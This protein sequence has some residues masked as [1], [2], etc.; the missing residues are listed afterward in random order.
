MFSVAFSWTESKISANLSYV[1]VRGEEIW[2]FRR[3]AR[4]IV[5]NLIR[6]SRLH[7]STGWPATCVLITV[8]E[9]QRYLATSKP[10]VK[11]TTQSALVTSK[12]YDSRIAVVCLRITLATKL[13]VRWNLAFALR[14]KEYGNA[15]FY[16]GIPYNYSNVY[17]NTFITSKTFHGVFKHEGL[18]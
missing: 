10:T 17:R 6:P 4:R 16:S 3:G 2:N 8:N 7:T 9:A 11:W 12:R 5:R 18:S 13:Y 15:M 1:T 14:H